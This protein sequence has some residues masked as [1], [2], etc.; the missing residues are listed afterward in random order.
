MVLRFFI[1]IVLLLVSSLLQASYLISEDHDLT[2]ISLGPKINFLVE[3]SPSVNL[4]N[5]RQ[6]AEQFDW[7][8]TSDITP[9]F[10]FNVPP[11]GF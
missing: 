4:E 11:I 3:D 10:G 1:S 8:T 5:L 6:N 7:Q 2:H 9:N